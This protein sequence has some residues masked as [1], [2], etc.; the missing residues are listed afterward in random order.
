MEK[1]W[2]FFVQLRNNNFVAFRFHTTLFLHNHSA[3]G[4]GTKCFLLPRI[5]FFCCLPA[6]S[7]MQKN[8]APS[9]TFV[10]QQHQKICK[11][12][13]AVFSLQKIRTTKENRTH[14]TEQL[15]KWYVNFPSNIIIVCRVPPQ[16]SYVVGRPKSV[17]IRAEDSLLSSYL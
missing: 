3:F 16:S 2:T 7:S 10:P 12:S 8:Q 17:S 4:C 5:L 14:S 13:L 6:H 9:V 11:N 15:V 1:S